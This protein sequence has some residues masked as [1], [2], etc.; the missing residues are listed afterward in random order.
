MFADE[1]CG[2]ARRKR[3]TVA[4]IGAG[5]RAAFEDRDPQPNPHLRILTP[6]RLASHDGWIGWPPRLDREVS[7]TSL[8]VLRAN[9]V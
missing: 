4:R 5:P 3:L 8:A 2:A 1:I 7:L 6:S 9:S